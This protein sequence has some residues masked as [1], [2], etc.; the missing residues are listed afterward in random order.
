MS[1]AKM[2]SKEMLSYGIAWNEQSM[3]AGKIADNPLFS[4]D[5]PEAAAVMAMTSA[6]CGMTSALWAVGS[7]ICRHLEAQTAGYKVTH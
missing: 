3:K 4:D 2:T 5:H 7:Q 1:Q 6:V